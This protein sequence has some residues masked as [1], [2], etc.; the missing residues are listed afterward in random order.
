MKTESL[1][2]FIAL[3]CEDHKPRLHVSLNDGP[4][5]PPQIGI[6]LADLITGVAKSLVDSGITKDSKAMSLDQVRSE[7][8]HWISCESKNPT[9]DIEMFKPS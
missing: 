8:M 9:D 5:S 2:P 7:I 6:M 1:V 3:Y 4:Q